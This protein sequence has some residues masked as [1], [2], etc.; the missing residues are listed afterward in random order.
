MICE[1]KFTFEVHFVLKHSEALLTLP[2]Y[3]RL[4]TSVATLERTA[5]EI[6]LFIRSVSLLINSRISEQLI[7]SQGGAYFEHKI[8]RR[9][10]LD[11]YTSPETILWLHH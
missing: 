4:K 8:K 5:L 10:K 2:N 6:V 1:Y 7:S 3:L 9:E 11:R